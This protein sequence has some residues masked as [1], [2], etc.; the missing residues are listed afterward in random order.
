MTR[1]DAQ[2]SSGSDRLRSLS[3][4]SSGGVFN[5][6]RS[7]RSLVAD[8]IPSIALG[9]AWGV[10]EHSPRSSGQVDAIDGTR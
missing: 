7:M 6:L 9:R 1:F 10:R 8:A 5:R 4:S 2:G 3:S